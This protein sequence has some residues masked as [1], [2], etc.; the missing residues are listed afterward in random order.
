MTIQQTIDKL[1]KDVWDNISLA[2]QLG[3]KYGEETITDNLLLELA[4]LKNYN[5]RIIQTP[6]DK[7]KDKGTDW[8]WFIGSQA[9]GWTRF[10]IQTKKSKP[11]TKKGDYDSL[12]HFVGTAK[13]IDILK[14][15]AKAN[16]AIPLY[17]FYNHFDKAIEKDHW[18]CKKDYDKKLL[19]W[20]VTPAKNVESALSSR[21]QRNFLFIHEQNETI[22]T[23]CLFDCPLFFRQYQEKTLVDKQV[24]IM[25]TEVKKIKNIPYYSLDQRDI[26]TIDTFPEELYNKEIKIYPRRI[27][28]FDLGEEELYGR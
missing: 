8:E 10:A 22:P 18:H 1:T 19:G 9:Y 17:S 14:I 26:M 15:F 3:T 20:T 21:G 23:K 11:D 4:K 12:N 13:Q 16:N 25:G 2:N 5:L 24:S 27:A 7:E 6:K 28:I